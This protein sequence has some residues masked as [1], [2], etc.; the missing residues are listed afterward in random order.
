MPSRLVKA[1]V[2]EPLKMRGLC[3]RAYPGHAHGCPN[4]G[5]RDTC[6]P[7]APLFEDAYINRDV[8]VIWNHFDLDAH[9]Q[10][11]RRRH[12][13][14]SE[15]QLYNCLYWQGTARA[16]LRQ[17]INDCILTHRQGQV[18]IIRC[19]EAQGVNVTETLREMGVD[20]QWPP[21]TVATQVALAAK[22]G[23]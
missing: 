20:I 5:Q 23:F 17:A 15:R 16:Q 19:P 12:P 22:R 13:A 9:V 6:P 7:R 2:Y 3:A 11:M 14:W 1:V 10:D 4:L 18:D 8:I 21:T